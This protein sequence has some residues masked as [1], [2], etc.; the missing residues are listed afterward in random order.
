MFFIL[1][2]LGNLTYGAGVS[3][4]F[5][6]YNLWFPTN[7]LYRFFVTPPRRAISLRTCLGLLAPWVQWLRMLRFLRSS[8]CTRLRSPTQQLLDFAVPC[9]LGTFARIFIRDVVFKKKANWLCSFWPGVSV[10]KFVISTL[11]ECT[12]E[13]FGTTWS[14]TVYLTHGISTIPKA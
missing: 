11:H 2:L 14:A 6:L 3:S 12:T 1:S 10:I 8:G 7:T 13:S 4:H 5:S 9:Y